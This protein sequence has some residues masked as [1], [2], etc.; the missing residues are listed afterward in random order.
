MREIYRGIL[1]FLWAEIVLLVLLMLFPE[2]AL[3][4]PR[5]MKSAGWHSAAPG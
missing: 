2:L 1:P 4:L 5:S 3:F